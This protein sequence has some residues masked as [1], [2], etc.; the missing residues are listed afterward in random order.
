MAEY[1]T[2]YSY[3]ISTL[4]VNLTSYAINIDKV[5]PMGKTLTSFLI[6]F[7]DIDTSL[8]FALVAS[9]N[10][11]NGVIHLQ[12]NYTRLKVQLSVSGRIFIM[13]H[14]LHIRNHTKL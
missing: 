6:S 8:C 3:H 9:V 12:C 4:I 13:P 14:M 5:F 7:S 2:V 1:R 11:T 10:T